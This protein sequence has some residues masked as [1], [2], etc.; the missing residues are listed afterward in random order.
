MFA[1]FIFLGQ[2]RAPRPRKLKILIW[3]TK[4]EV[5]LYILMVLFL[6]ANYSLIPKMYIFCC[7]KVNFNH[8]RS[9]K[10]KIYLNFQILPNLYQFQPVTIRV[11]LHT[12]KYVH[13]WNQQKYHTY[14]VLFK[15]MSTWGPKM[16]FYFSIL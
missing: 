12:T 14:I 13:F 11:D 3:R 6:V 15:K 16:S 10:V 2:S 7:L 4:F 1:Y 8:W 9:K 5:A